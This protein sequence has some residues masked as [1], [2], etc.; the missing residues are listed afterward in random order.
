[1][2]APPPSTHNVGRFTSLVLTAIVSLCLIMI[3]VAGF[4]KYQVDL[5]Q[6]A[7]AAPDAALT[8]GQDMSGQIRRN[9][10]YSGYLGSAQTFIT[11]HDASSLA[12]MKTYLKTAKDTADHVPERVATETRRDMQSILSA[13]QNVTDKAEKSL[14]DTAVSFSGSDL[15]PLYAA[16]P[17]MDARVENA[18][19]TSRLAAQSHLQFWSM[20][21][22]LVAWAS[23][24]IASAMAVN[25]YLSLR[26]RNSA[27][28]RALAQSVKNMARGDMRTP[29]W[30]HGT[31]G[32]DWRTGPAPSIW[33]GYQFSQLPDIALLSDNGPLRMKFE[34]QT[35]SMFDAMMQNFGRDAEKLREQAGNLTEAITKQDEAIGLISSRVEAVLHNVEKRGLDGDQ[36]VRRAVQNIASSAESLIHAQQHTAEQLGRLLPYMQERAQGM[37][38]IAQLTGKQVS[39]ALQNL[40]VTERGL[41]G[42]AEQSD[43]AIKKLSTTA[44]ELGSRLF[45]AVNLLQASGKVL[46]ETTEKTQSRLNEVLTRFGSS[47][48]DDFSILSSSTQGGGLASTADQTQLTDILAALERLQSKLEESVH[49]HANATEAQIDLLITQSSGLLTQTSTAAQT[50]AAAGDHLRAERDKL[51][52][53]LRHVSGNLRSSELATPAASICPPFST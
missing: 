32:Y 29:L 19:A 6:T 27:P 41:R 17:I 4:L 38:E 11:T 43:E 2:T 35:K 16:L 20:L 31:A 23:L 36:Q 33:P 18:A 1:M 12:D 7:L 21:L 39:L 53:T 34:G 47:S 37:A 45:G 25:V 15:I 48:G 51:D 50:L 42:S 30:G 9:L 3:G 46:S 52:D 10:G 40:T 24:I 49:Q 28:M 22:T 8:S 26:D 13:F 5:A 14:A 44:D